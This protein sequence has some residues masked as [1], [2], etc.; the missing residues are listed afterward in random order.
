MSMQSLKAVTQIEKAGETMG[1]NESVT[2]P[3][4]DDVGQAYYPMVPV[5]T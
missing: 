3:R 5:V 1:H 4:I 2:I